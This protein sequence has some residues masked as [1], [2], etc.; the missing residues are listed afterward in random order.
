MV[1]K[2]EDI[3]VQKMNPCMYMYRYKQVC[4]GRVVIEHMHMKH[5]CVNE[6]PP[7]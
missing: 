6:E 4:I 5:F 7:I 1:I 3:H 2:V